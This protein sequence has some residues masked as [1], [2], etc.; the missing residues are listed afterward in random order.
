MATIRKVP[1]KS[2]GVSYRAIIKSGGR[3]VASKNF[4]RRR[5]AAQWAARIE[6][7]RER[8]AALGNPDGARTFGSVA[9]LVISSPAKDLSRDLR[10]RWWVKRIGGEAIGRI[11]TAELRRNL[12]EY[13]K[14]HA[15]ASTNRLKAAASSV[16]RY[17]QREG[18]V[19]ANPAHQLPHQTEPRGRVRWLEPEERRRLLAACDAS[20]W[21]R[22]GLL[23]RYLLGTGCRLGE[24]LSTRWCDVDLHERHVF[25]PDTK[26]GCARVLT[27]PEPL[28]AELKKHRRIGVGLVFGRDDAPGEPFHFRKHWNAARAAADLPDLR[29]HDLRHD[30]ASQLA[31]AGATLH[32]VAEVLGHKSVQTTKRYAHLSTAHKQALTDRVLGDKL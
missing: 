12:A 4:S 2:G 23:A 8:M 17:A 27:L 29:L 15:P 32:E 26:N 25:L 3:Q 30:V 24:A 18:W 6:G 22:L 14:D 31:M 19:T 20:G 7:D 1:L 16:F 11:E 28:V 21:P 10:I 9:A 13:A 5:D